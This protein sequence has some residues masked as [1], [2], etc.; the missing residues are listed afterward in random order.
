MHRQSSRSTTN[1]DAIDC[2][3]NTNDLALEEEVHKRENDYRR[4]DLID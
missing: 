4:F 2:N 3:I 1:V